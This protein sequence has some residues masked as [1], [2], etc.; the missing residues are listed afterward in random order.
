M[1]IS[2]ASRVEEARELVAIS[3]FDGL[4]CDALR[5]A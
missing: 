4:A 3:A 5:V 1:V 2:S